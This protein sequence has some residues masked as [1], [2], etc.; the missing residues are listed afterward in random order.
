MDGVLVFRLCRRAL[1]FLLDGRLRFTHDGERGVT[2]YRRF[3]V[4]R[5]ATVGGRQVNGE[6]AV[7]TEALEAA[8]FPL[9][10]GELALCSNAWVGPTGRGWSNWPWLVQLAVGASDDVVGL[11]PDF[12]GAEE[13]ADCLFRPEGAV[14]LPWRSQ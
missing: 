4:P 5:V 9:F 14:F 3:G 12:A 8:V 10:L 7:V 6:A 11:L 13:E 1:Y 2:R